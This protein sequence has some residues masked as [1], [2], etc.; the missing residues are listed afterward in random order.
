MDDKQIKYIYDATGSKLQKQIYVNNNSTS[1]TSY[2]GAFIYEKSSSSGSE[3]LQCFCH[4]EGY[5]EKVDQVY[6][7]YFYQYKNHLGN[8]RLNY[9]QGEDGLMIKEENNYYPFGLKHKGYNIVIV[10][11]DHKY[12]YGYKE[13]QD[14]LG[15][16]W[17]D[18]HA[19]NYDAVLGRWMNINPLSEMTPFVST[20]TYVLNNPILFK[21]PDGKRVYTNSEEA[22][23]ILTNTLTELLG[24][25]HGFY[26]D[27]K[28]YLK[29]K[30]GKAHRKA[31][32]QFSDE[33]KSIL[34]GF[35][36]IT[37]NKKY[38]IDVFTKEN[39][40]FFYAKL[41][42][43]EVETEQSDDG[44]EV[45]KKDQGGKPILKD[46]GTRTSQIIT[47]QKGEFGGGVFV[48]LRGHK[49]AN[50]IFFPDIAKNKRF[51]GEGGKFTIGSISAVVVHELL[52]HGVN[53]VRGADPEANMGPSIHN[54]YYQNQAF[55]ILNSPTRTSHKD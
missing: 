10:G 28:G 18:F 46:K 22:Q 43:Y 47:L 30:G 42:D 51:K 52:D 54:V 38:T 19:R 15:L 25:N 40:S 44:R 7:Q 23:L 29:H 1:I 16:E 50:A 31:K 3:Q 13:E 49:D 12:G 45:I 8:V 11:R 34:E 20:Y 27:K 4:A 35:T 37:S 53:F 55:I 36:E 9:A 24:D 39:D 5:V 41:L 48:G 6:Y 32:K 17:M 33:Q 14:E 2:A 26:F 21:D